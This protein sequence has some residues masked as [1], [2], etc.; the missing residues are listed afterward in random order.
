MPLAPDERLLQEILLKDD[1]SGWRML[2]GCMLLNLTSRRQVDRVWPLLFRHWPNAGV[3][4]DLHSPYQADE[5][6]RLLKPLGL[7]NRRFTT[8]RR[9]SEQWLETLDAHREANVV[10][11]KYHG[12][13]EYA[14]DSWIIFV[15]GRRDIIPTDKEL[16]AYLGLARLEAH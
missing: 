14:R 2:V 13:G 15:Q 5:V 4:A 12:V 8:I 10:E 1:P 11:M 9:F 3:A 6:A 7:A 16:R